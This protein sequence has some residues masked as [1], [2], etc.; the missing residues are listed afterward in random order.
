MP[1]VAGEL[2]GMTPQQ[3]WFVTFGKREQGPLDV[4]AVRALV[5]SGQI[6][7]DTPIR[8]GDLPQ[9]VP[10]GSIKG[11]LPASNASE[12]KAPSGI[13]S[14]AAKA[15]SSPQVRGQAAVS[16]SSGSASP[17]RTTSRVRKA[18]APPPAP[19]EE[20]E[21]E[22][23][24]QEGTP[25]GRAGIH[26]RLVSLLIDFSLIGGAAGTLLFL[27]LRAGP[28]AEENT[29]ILV[30]TARVK[31]TAEQN[32][33]GEARPSFAAWPTLR[34]TWEEEVA[35]KRAKLEEAEKALKAVPG[36]GKGQEPTHEETLAKVAVENA[37]NDL[38]YRA[39]T[40][41]YEIKRYEADQ[42]AIDTARVQSGTTA[43]LMGGFAAVI[44]LLIAPLMEGLFAAT[45]GKLLLGLRTVDAGRK[46]IGLVAALVRHACRGAL[47][48]HAGLFQGDQL[49]G[50]HDRWSKT[51]V[52]TADAVVRRARG[53]GATA[54][55]RR[56]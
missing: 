26:Q 47:V 19:A 6:V 1:F 11:L 12:P 30:E 42:R 20:P 53:K 52:V 27:A 16:V 17:V 49:L 54:R 51:E 8:R 36:A 28:Q 3:S 44:A 40:L 25:A 9:A 2:Y 43:R 32:G 7:A 13:R 34:P 33:K 14:P 56:R 10:A 21:A 22:D 4:A 31:A 35:A 48:V 29:R 55:V 41:D 50:W 5:E 15:P 37:K 23:E 38:D 46:P 18:A 39:K 24:G 45:P